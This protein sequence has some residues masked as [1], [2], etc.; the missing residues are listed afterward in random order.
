MRLVC[1]TCHVL[2]PTHAD[3][4][5]RRPAAHYVANLESSPGF[6]P[7]SRSAALM[8]ACAEDFDDI[9]ADGGGYVLL[10]EFCA[11]IE[12]RAIQKGTRVLISL[13]DS[14]M[15]ERVPKNAAPFLGTRPNISESHSEISTRLPFCITQ[16]RHWHVT[17]SPS[18]DRARQPQRAPGRAA[19]RA[20]ETRGCCAD[21]SRRRGS[22]VRRATSSKARSDTPHTR[23]RQSSPR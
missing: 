21:D 4:A 11:W 9:D 19:R 7:R 6:Y 2:A 12:A 18:C 23:R 14:L 3:D 5:H 22:R 10:A 16:A 1:T 15:F 8:G 17:A 13:W 20:P